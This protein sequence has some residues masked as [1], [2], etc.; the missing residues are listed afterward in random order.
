MSVRHDRIVRTLTNL[1]LRTI[2]LVLFA[3]VFTAMMIGASSSAACRGA[4]GSGRLQIAY[5]TAAL[6]ALTPF[7]G[8][9]H[10]RATLY[11]LRGIARADLGQLDLA[12]RDL[13]TALSKASFGRPGPVLKGQTIMD[14]WKSVPMDLLDRMNALDPQ[15][16]AARV[17]A[18]VLSPYQPITLTR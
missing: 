16:P 12:R 8:E 9:E 5:C 6:T 11:A 15:S 17:W 4:S 14:V 7:R 2:V 18:E 10:K 13:K 3:L 1:N